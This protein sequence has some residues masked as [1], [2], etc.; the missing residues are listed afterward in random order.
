MDK[1]YHRDWQREHATSDPAWYEERK[2]SR[3]QARREKKKRWVAFMGG[4]CVDCKGMYHP[5]AFTFHHV[6]P[7]TK[8]AAKLGRS[9]NKILMLSD[10]QILHELQKCILLCL[11]CHAI[12]HAMKG[13]L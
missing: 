1:H 4:K 13:W 3:T 7:A 9:T 10:E 11:N 8:D 12:R 2:Q 6:D 5:I